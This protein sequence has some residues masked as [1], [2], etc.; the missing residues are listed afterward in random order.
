MLLL[1]TD[2]GFIKEYGHV[3]HILSDIDDSG[4]FLDATFHLLPVSMPTA[5]SS[6]PTVTSSA[7]DET[8]TETGTL[9]SLIIACKVNNS[10][11]K[12]EHA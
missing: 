6:M 8:D 10:N 9:P 1:V 2:L 5:T 11:Y 3:W 7:N 12:L 4:D